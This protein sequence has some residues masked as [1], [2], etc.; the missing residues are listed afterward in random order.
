MP[1][2]EVIVIDND[3]EE[4][5]TL[6]YDDDEEIK[7]VDDDTNYNFTDYE[8]AINKPKINGVELIKN[9]TAEQL[10]LQGKMEALTNLDIE[11]LLNRK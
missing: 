3:E 4:S 5:L 1:D 8:I 6:I 7:V 11:K 10:N 9:K 2:E